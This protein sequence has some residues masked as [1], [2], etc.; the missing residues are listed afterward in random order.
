MLCSLWSSTGP[1]CSASWSVWTRRTVIR[2]AALA[3]V[4]SGMCVAGFT[5]EVTFCAV[6]PS[7][8]DGPRMLNIMAGMAQSTPSIG[9]FP[10]FD[11]PRAVFPR[12]FVHVGMPKTVEDPQLQFIMAGSQFLDKVVDVPFPV[13]VGFF[14][15]LTC[16]WL[17]ND[18]CVAES[19]QKLLRFRSG[20]A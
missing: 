20:S 4:G 7:V 18:R 8:V 16:P 15:L 19:V 9:W 14:R 2:E 5:G 17:C 10:W 3:V 13:H 11:A 6:F 12:A 1:C